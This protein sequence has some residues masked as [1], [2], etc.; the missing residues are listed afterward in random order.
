MEFTTGARLEIRITPADVGKRVSL[1]SLTGSDARGGRFTDTLGV[2][3][4]WDDGVLRL[5][6]R[7]GTR[8][9]VAQSALV[10]A[11]V[12]PAT[13]A[14]RGGPAASAAEL[15]RVAARGWPPLEA[16]PL[17]EWTLRAAEGF[18]R[19]ANSALAVGDPGVGLDEALERTGAWYA[20]R[21]LPAYV[22]LADDA[23]P[24]GL[25]ARL[26][27]R[28][29][30]PEAATWTQTAALARVADLAGG[31]G[32]NGA[33]ALTRKATLSRTADEGW[34]ALYHRAG[35]LTPA[36]EAVLHG[37]P[38][39][40]A[41]WFATVP[42]DSPTAPAAIGRCVVDGRWAGFA[43]VETAPEHRRTGLAR[44]V[45]AA[46]AGKALE[47]GASAAYLQVEADNEGAHALYAGLGFTTHHGYCYFRRPGD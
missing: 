38:P 25:A 26:S 19:R 30:L 21:G 16:E 9:Q 1:R 46:L 40:G 34:C 33:G 14:R 45:M 24:E 17:G 39:G 3:T 32:D 41:V 7:D 27:A 47:E 15:A 12:V 4:S 13:P 37:A 18:T 2:L 44:R 23:A 11:K 28:G 22:Q 42:G 10:A 35:A 6:R 8:A 43:A 20:A 36:A 29:W 5:L 31:G